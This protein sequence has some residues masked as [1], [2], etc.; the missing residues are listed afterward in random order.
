ME[1]QKINHKYLLEHGY[2]VDENKTAMFQE[3]WKE[4]KDWCKEPLRYYYSED[5]RVCI[6]HR[7]TNRYGEAYDIHI[8]N[9]DYE[10]VGWLEALYVDEFE[11]F[12]KLVYDED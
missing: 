3:Y 4:E 1:R 10:P 6:Q 12:I 2:V 7:W 8:D 9:R 11:N 5:R